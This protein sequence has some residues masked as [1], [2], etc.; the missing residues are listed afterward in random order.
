MQYRKVVALAKEIAEEKNW[1]WLGDVK[2]V[3]YRK[4]FFGRFLWRV[5]TNSKC[6]GCNIKIVI[7]DETGEVIESA[8]LPR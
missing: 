8:Y 5:T 4:G 7:D 2:V 3:K 6:R 1:I